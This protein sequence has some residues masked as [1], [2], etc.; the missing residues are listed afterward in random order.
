ML[1]LLTIPISH[2]C[3]KARWGLERA[4]L[5]YREE[6]HLQ[7]L[8]WAPVRRAGGHRTVPV[9]VTPEGVLGESHAILR[10]ADARM[11]PTWRL[12]PAPLA[13]EAI[14]LEREL[15][16]EYG[17]ETQRLFTSRIAAAP[18]EL[19]LKMNNQTAPRWEAAAVGLALPWV[20]GLVRRY[21]DARPAAV[22]TAHDRVR[23]TL[24]RLGQ[25]LA[26][27]RPYLCGDRLTGADIAFA[28]LS[29]P[30]L[31]PRQYGVPLPPQEAF[32]EHVQRLFRQYDGYPALAHARWL[33]AT[34]RHRTVPW[35]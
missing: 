17:V 5:L 6:P 21:A 22:T 20:L 18:K 12:Y 23:R 27:G 24:D 7:L 1:R 13:A 15:D 32:P 28:A 19:V 25:R 9:L 8:H 26:D 29:A 10:Y 3:D 14:R 11:P 34:E 2:Y 16:R 4:G 31:V 30:I 33:Y 35:D